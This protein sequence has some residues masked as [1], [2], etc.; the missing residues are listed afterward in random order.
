MNRRTFLVAGAATLVSGCTGSIGGGES[1]T[2]PGPPPGP[3]NPSGRA[4]CQ[5]GSGNIISINGATRVFPGVLALKEAVILRPVL[6]LNDGGEVIGVQKASGRKA[7]GSIELE[8]IKSIEV[9]G[10]SITE[11]AANIPPMGM[12]ANDG[13]ADRD[14]ARRTLVHSQAVTLE[15]SFNFEGVVVPVFEPGK[16]ERD[17]T[18]SSLWKIGAFG[19]YVSLHTQSKQSIPDKLQNYANSAIRLK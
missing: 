6:Q 13:C 7:D 1:S 9:L 17:V 10:W 8:N 2:P 15:N 19:V 16:S 3:G 14:G 4:E 18:H 5:F 12:I 11:T